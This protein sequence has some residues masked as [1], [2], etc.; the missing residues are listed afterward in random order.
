MRERDD[1]NETYLTSFV[2][3]VFGAPLDGRTEDNDCLV[4]RTTRTRED[5]ARS[6]TEAGA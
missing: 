6:R 5:D 4:H 2:V 1:E 3:H